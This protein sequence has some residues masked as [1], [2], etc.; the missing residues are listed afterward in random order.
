[1]SPRLLR[2]IAGGIH[3]EAAA[4]R[5][6]VIA[7]SGSV[8]GSTLKAVSDFCRRIDAAGM[9]DRFYRVNLFAGSD[10]DLNSVVVPLYKGPVFGGTAYGNAT[11]T[12]NAFASAD[13]VETGSAGGLKGN[14]STKRL[15]TGLQQGDVSNNGT[16]HLSVYY[17]HKTAP[18]NSV[19]WRVIG[20]GPTGDTN[21][22]YYDVATLNNATLRRHAHGGSAA[23][24]D[25]S[26]NSIAAW[27]TNHLGVTRTG[28]TT[29]RDWFGSS[30]FAGIATSV[31][32]SGLAAA[33]TVFAFNLDGTNPILHANATLGGYSIG[34]ALT[35]AQI[36][37]FQ[38]AMESF[39]AALGR[40]VSVP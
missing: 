26:E 13:Y 6:A 12:P 35:D 22:Y 10:A 8:S 15:N 1:M 3:P 20:A 16:G 4:W 18:A 7:N 29:L 36:T 9:R 38:S 17:R 37:A 19:T 21:A 11:D 31:S 24:F 34:L 39:Q 2:P 40:N 23:T 5:T 25:N 33:I 28:A 27:A 30:I 14:G 32:P